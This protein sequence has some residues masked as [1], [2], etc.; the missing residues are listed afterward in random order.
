MVSEYLISLSSIMSERIKEGQGRVSNLDEEND[1]EKK[2]GKYGCETCKKNF[3][4]SSNLRRHIKRVHQ[5]E[6]VVV[7]GIS[8][9][10]CEYKCRDNYQLKVHMRSHTK[11]KPF[12]CNKCDFRSSKKEDCKRHMSS[13]KGP[14]YKC[15]NC[16]ATFKSRN[17]INDHHIWDNVCGTLASK[18]S[19]EPQIIKAENDRSI[20]KIIISKEMSVVGVNCNELLD[21]EL[22][23][24]RPRKTRCGLCFNCTSVETCGKCKVCINVSSNSSKQICLKRSCNNPIELYELKKGNVTIENNEEIDDDNELHVDVSCL[25]EE[26]DNEIIYKNDLLIDG[27]VDMFDNSDKNILVEEINCAAS[28]HN[29]SHHSD[30]HSCILMNEDV[31]QL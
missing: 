2:D 30:N 17:G 14:K 31:I 5:S 18:E 25:S 8:C 20:V 27:T 4:V 22:F 10:M 11:E 16:Q 29:G 3:S 15:N 24:K 21:K 28:S 13:C 12:N 7:K 6:N 26:N 23:E 9:E 19:E 1:K